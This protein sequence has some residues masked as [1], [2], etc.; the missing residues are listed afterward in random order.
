VLVLFVLAAPAALASAPAAQVTADVGFSGWIVPDVWIPIRVEVTGEQAVEGTVEIQVGLA[1]HRHPLRV[2]AGGRQRV[3]LSAVIA[4]PRRP[5]VVSVR[6]STGSIVTQQRVPLARDRIVSGVVLALTAEA[7]GLE[8][9]SGSPRRQAGAYLRERDLPDHWAAYEGVDL[10]V[11]RD[12]DERAT[13]DRQR[14]ALREWVAQG[15]RLLVTGERLLRQRLPWLADLLPAEVTPLPATAPAPFPGLGPQSI[16][17]LRP[18]PGATR[19]PSAGVPL[20]VSRAYG[21]GVV[22]AWAFDAFAPSVRAWSGRVALW[23]QV[24]PSARLQ[25]VARPSLTEV[26]PTTRTLSG[27]AQTQI[28]VL[29]ILYVLAVRVVLRR[30]AARPGRWPSLAAV[31]L[32]F[33]LALYATAAGARRAASALVQMSVLESTGAADLAR[34][35][36]YVALLQPYGGSYMLTPPEDSLLRPLTPLH[37]TASA[38]GSISGMTEPGVFFFETVRMISLP[39]TGTAASTT[40]GIEFAYEN[41]TGGVV[42]A[43]AVY[44]NGQSQSLPD[45]S[46]RLTATLAPGAWMPADRNAATGDFA[47]DA[48][49]WI[50]ARLDGYN[51]PAIIGYKTLWLL[52][53]VRDARVAVHLQGAGDQRRLDLLLSPI[54]VTGGR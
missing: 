49:A 29:A 47:R 11:L 25:P 8:F 6:D 26:V 46:A 37:Y 43:P 34:V 14:R 20:V 4:D 52:G 22:T 50:T 23:Q 17:V 3:G 16:A 24:L 12:V 19:V 44:L 42:S 31:V 35:T 40:T 45:I 30:F 53:E 28:V 5:L 41:R 1:V 36:T 7:A 51:T 33:T 13:S 27:I 10:V 21:R 48:R 15:G 32:V 18:K 39:V 2:A 54:T 38:D 9:L